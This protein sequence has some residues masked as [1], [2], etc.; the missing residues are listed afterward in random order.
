MFRCPHCDKSIEITSGQPEH[1][2]SFWQS[3]YGSSVSLGGGSLIAIALI[4]AVCSGT[5]TRGTTGVQNDIR[6]LDRKIERI[7]Q[8]LTE[9]KNENAASKVVPV[10]E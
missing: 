5:S 10:V 7:E 8:M 3:Q 9:L 1:K 6:N 4:V 2:K